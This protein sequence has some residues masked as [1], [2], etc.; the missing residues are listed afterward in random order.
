MNEAHE[1]ILVVDDSPE[2][3]E[4]TRRFL[5]SEGYR[6]FTVGGVPE[7]IRLLGEQPVDL[8]ITD[9]KMPKAS[10]LD[11]IRHVREN[12]KD[13]E[14]IMITGYATIEGAVAAVKLGAEEYLAKP[15]TRE[16]LVAAVE[17]SLGALRVRRAAGSGEPPASVLGLVGESEGMRR[18]Q[19][20]LS[21]EALLD[22]PVLLVGERGSGKEAAA[23]ALHYGGPRA[24]SL[25][26]HLDCA[27]VPPERV[28]AELFGDG[29]A[30]GGRAGYVRLAQGSTLYLAAVEA[31][32]ATVQERLVRE[33]LAP[34]MPRTATGERAS[35]LRLLAGTTLDH[36]SFMRRGS[37][38]EDLRQALTASAIH[39]PPLRER[40]DDVLLLARNALTRSA[41]L[42]GLSPSR[43][44]DRALGVLRSYHWPGNVDELEYVVGSVLGTAETTL[45]DVPDLPSLMRFSALRGAGMHRSLAEVELHHIQNVLAGVGG[46]K[47]KAAEILGID[48]KTL[49]EKLKTAE[50]TAA[51]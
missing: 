33:C 45:I 25:F 47:T 44:T 2:T 50:E 39:L 24:E 20:A 49:R 43:F 28:A 22:G 36:E 40:G 3:L 6:V 13:T 4:L 38:R 34:A 17:R 42:H 41:R 27:A 5:G 9:L 19:A 35:G 51:P 14:V 21:R 15:F 26:L 1:T 11:L 16:E 7:A 30:V 31:L 32:P 10:G 12:L 46:N 29:L 8:V 23:R 18:V 37:V 48:R